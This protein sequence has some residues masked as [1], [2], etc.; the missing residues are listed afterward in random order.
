M[1]DINQWEYRVKTFGAILRGI[2]DEE[3]TTTLNEWGEEGW[4]VVSAQGIENTNKV[5]IIA[6]RPLTTAVR[7]RRS[8]PE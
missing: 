6:R 8:L 1:A 4:E 5:R 3:F 7:R 2:K